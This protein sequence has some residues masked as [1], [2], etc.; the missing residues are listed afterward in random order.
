[1]NDEYY[2]RGPAP[3]IRR[4]VLRKNTVFF[5]QISERKSNSDFFG[6]LDADELQSLAENVARAACERDTNRFFIRIF[7]RRDGAS[8]VETVE[9]AAKIEDI[10]RNYAGLHAVDGFLHLFGKRENVLIRSRSAFSRF[11]TFSGSVTFALSPSL[12]IMLQVL[13]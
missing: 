12:F 10:A 8:L 3:V 2:G 7:A 6:V 4:W 13:A 11:S 1:M 5:E 9:C